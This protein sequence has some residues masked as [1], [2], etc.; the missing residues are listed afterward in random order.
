MSTWLPDVAVAEGASE[1]DAV[2]G[3]RPDLFDAYRDFESVFWTHR[4]LDAELLDA[5]RARCA[6]V[7]RADGAPLEP[8]AADDPSSRL[9]ACLALAEQFVID[10]HCV[11]AEMRDAVVAHVG[12]AGLVALV[13]ALAVFDGFT[14]FRTQLEIA[15]EQ[16]AF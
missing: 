10:P 16:G 13:E 9:A 2:F 3:L 15:P 11:T 7:V 4:L 6:Q 8:V 5:C 12:D 14:R 1:F